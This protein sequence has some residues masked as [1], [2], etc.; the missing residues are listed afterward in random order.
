[1]RGARDKRVCALAENIGFSER[2]KDKKTQRKDNVGGD[3]KA[4]KEFL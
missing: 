4:A 1:L 3:E 2:N